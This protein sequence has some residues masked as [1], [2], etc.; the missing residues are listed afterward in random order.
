MNCVGTSSLCRF[1]AVGQSTDA[2]FSNA[3]TGC[4]FAEQLGKQV[5]QNVVNSHKSCLVFALCV[6]DPLPRLGQNINVEHA[7]TKELSLNANY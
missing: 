4:T 5:M 2:V 1:V 3:H 6:L 7:V